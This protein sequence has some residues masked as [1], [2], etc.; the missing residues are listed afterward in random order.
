VQ[1]L[2]VALPALQW[3]ADHALPSGVLAEQLDPHNGSP[4][5]VSPL[6]WSHATVMTT[7]VQYLLKHAAITGGRAGTVAELT[8]AR[9]GR[10]A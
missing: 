3:T 9:R 1:E 8:L 7:V 6:T 5:S 2:E 10:G 4:V